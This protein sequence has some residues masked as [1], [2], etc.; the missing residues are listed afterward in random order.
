MNKFHLSFVIISFLAIAV[1]ACSGGASNQEATAQALSESFSLTS[2]AA[3]ADA[4]SA[5][6]NLAT[7]QAQA[8]QSSQDI[9]ATQSAANQLSSEVQSATATAVAPLIAELPAYG[10][11]PSD[12][13]MAWIHPP[14]TLDIQGYLQYDYANYFIGTTATDFVISADITWDTSYGTS[15]CG[16]VLRSDGNE[17]ALNQYLAIATRGGNGRVIF[18]SM[19]EGEVENAI[20]HYAYGK[21][22]LFDWQNGTTNRITVVARGEIFSIYTNGT[23]VGE[24]A[25]GKPPVLV[26]P[27]PPV[28]PPEG[29]SNDIQEKYEL[30]LKEYDDLV[31][32]MTTRHQ[33]NIAIYQP[34]TPYFERG[35]VALVALSESGRT[36]C[37]FDNTWLWIMNE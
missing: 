34:D 31:A 37:Q 35:F 5:N 18:S 36:I 11:D 21:D 22:P 8:T 29:S 19:V 26:L 30:E 25:A 2:T 13:Y 1:S 10:V 9:A 23:K 27:L 28:A 7:V 3:A 24:V 14:V 33:Q 12:G 16:F 17:D 4:F 15:G 32:Q 20:D 6:D